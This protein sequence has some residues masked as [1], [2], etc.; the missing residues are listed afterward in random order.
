MPAWEAPDDNV[1]A[2]AIMD[3]T[4]S[5]LS[6]G[7]YALR[8]DLKWGGARQRGGGRR[9]GGRDG[10]WSAQGGAISRRLS[11]TAFWKLKILLELGQPSAPQLVRRTRRLMP[12]VHWAQGWLCKN[13]NGKF[14]AL[15]YYMWKWWM[16]SH[17]VRTKRCQQGTS[18][19]S[20][21]WRGAI[22]AHPTHSHALGWK[23]TAYIICCY[24]DNA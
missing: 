22:R 5:A 24:F 7:K 21:L 17:V 4:Q 1:S 2:L 9:K 8:M 3:G 12:T 18:Q 19:G 16:S 10:W 20:R 23:S 11:P 6:S 13:K 14:N 15:C